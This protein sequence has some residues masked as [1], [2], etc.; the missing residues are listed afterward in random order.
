[1]PIFDWSSILYTYIYIWEKETDREV[2]T[3]VETFLVSA[4]ANKSR[5]ICRSAH[6]HR[7]PTGKQTR[8]LLDDELIPAAAVES[9]SPLRYSIRVNVHRTNRSDII[10]M[11]SVEAII[12][13]LLLLFHLFALSLAHCNGKKPIF[14][15]NSKQKYVF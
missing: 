2:Y 14:F 3:L 5:L 1:M 13:L 7:K 10:I 11:Y 15:F 8:G 9:I 12:Q 6:K 4:S